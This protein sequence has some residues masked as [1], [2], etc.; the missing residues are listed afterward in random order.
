[1]SSREKEVAERVERDRE[2]VRERASMSRTSSR[3]GTE[4]PPIHRPRTPP[5]TGPPPAQLSPRASAAAKAALVPNV[6]PT[7]SFAAAAKRESA[8]RGNSVDEG[9]NSSVEQATDA[10]AEVTI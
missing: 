1:M 4:R 2:A 3:T 5:S 6:R 10:I 7:L 8:E 9:Q